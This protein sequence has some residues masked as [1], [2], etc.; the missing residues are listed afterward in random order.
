MIV[1][2][3][4]SCPALGGVPSPQSM[5]AVKPLLKAPASF[6]V[7]IAT[8]PLHGTPSV[9]CR[10]RAPL[11][12]V[13]GATLNGAGCTTTWLVAVAMLTTGGT[14]TRVTETGTVSGRP[15]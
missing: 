11:G 4:L 5:L 15:V 14:A 7:T 13:G 2:V 8:T 12:R 9:V 6:E 3:P 1:P 10:V